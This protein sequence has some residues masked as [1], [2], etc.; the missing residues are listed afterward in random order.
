MSPGINSKESI[1]PAYVVQPVSVNFLRNPVR[2]NRAGRDANI[3]R[4]TDNRGT[5]ETLDNTYG[6]MSTLAG[7]QHQRIH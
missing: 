1:P 2:V 5:I 6:G 7:T 3:S 4:D